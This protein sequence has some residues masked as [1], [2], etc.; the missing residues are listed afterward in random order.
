MA[1]PFGW[2]RCS[3]KSIIRHS[4]A[5]RIVCEEAKDCFILRREEALIQKEIYRRKTEG[6]QLSL[7]KGITND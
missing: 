5:C 7:F 6:V 4:L 3:E 1:V 2:I